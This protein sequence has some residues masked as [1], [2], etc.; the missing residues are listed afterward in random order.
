MSSTA[1]RLAVA[2]AAAPR[3]RVAAPRPTSRGG[4]RPA[5]AR[6]STN[7]AG[8]T[9]ARTTAPT[10]RTAATAR[11]TAATA[12]TAATA[13]RTATAPRTAATARATAA[14][15]ARATTNAPLL[16]V[17]PRIRRRRAG[18]LVAACC[19]STFAVMLGLTFFQAKIA[20][21]QMRI[22]GVARET[23]SAQEDYDR[24]RL[25]VARLQS[26]DAIVANASAQ[27]LGQ[28][29]SVIYVA[30]RQQDVMAVVAA[31]G[32]GQLQ[33]GASAASGADRSAVK[34]VVGAAG[35]MP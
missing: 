6:G 34:A 7:S 33:G 11:T 26:P 8:R 29:P 16:V 30:P 27:G 2:P 28:P 14:Q 31:G 24:L 21:E 23:Q 12:R 10:S 9:T 17:Q 22:D 13:A 18:A 4:A 1:S 3:P 20:A 15:S 32:I 25:A 19:V 5:E 35:A